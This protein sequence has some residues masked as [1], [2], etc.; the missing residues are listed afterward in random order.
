MLA[1]FSR[2]YFERFEVPYVRTWARDS[3]IFSMIL[4]SLPKDLLE[5]AITYFFETEQRTYNPPWFK[6]TLN[7]LLRDIAKAKQKKKLVNTDS[8]RYLA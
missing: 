8:E 3:R 6:A 5:K 1:Y 4:K 7:D 2:K